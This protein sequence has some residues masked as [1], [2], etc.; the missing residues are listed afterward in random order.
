MNLENL[1]ITK[2]FNLSSKFG[3]LRQKRQCTWHYGKWQYPFLLQIHNLFTTVSI[4]KCPLPHRFIFTK[5]ISLW[6]IWVAILV[7]W[8]EFSDII[9]LTSNCWQK[10]W[11]GQTVNQSFWL[12]KSKMWKIVGISNWIMFRTCPACFH[13]LSDTLRSPPF[14]VV[15]VICIEAIPHLNALCYW[16]CPHITLSSAIF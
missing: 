2:I 6:F 16:F 15:S 13:L 10:C 4:E 1:W 5:M 14:F 9:L 12:W 7:C 11:R 8:L 3:K